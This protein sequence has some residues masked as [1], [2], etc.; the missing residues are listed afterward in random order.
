MPV[1]TNAISRVAAWNT[2]GP[3]LTARLSSHGEPGG[4]GVARRRPC[5]RAHTTMRMMRQRSCA[6]GPERRPGSDCARPGR[7]VPPRAMTATPGASWRRL[8]L[9]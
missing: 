4:A 8:L 9:F 6:R 3:G 2:S 5:P 1:Q 7:R